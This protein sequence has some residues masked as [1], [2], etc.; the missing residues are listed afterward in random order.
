M[1]GVLLAQVDDTARA[2]ES[3][4]LPLHILGQ[5]Q[6][7]GRVGTL[8]GS[9]YD[10]AEDEVGD[11]VEEHLHAY[12]ARVHDAGVNGIH[13]DAQL[14][15]ALGQ[16]ECE[17]RD[18]QFAVAIGP[19]AQEETLATLLKHVGKVEPSQG[20]HA[21]SHVDYTSPLGH[22]RQEQA[23]EQVRAHIVHADGALQ[24]VHGEV[25]ARLQCAGIVHQSV[26]APKA[27]LDGK[28]KVAHGLQVGQVDA[29]NLNVGVAGFS[30]QFLALLLCLG[31][32]IA[33]H[34]GMVSGLGH[35]TG[36]LHA[37][38]SVGTGNDGYF[39]NY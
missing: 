3:A 36:F 22:Q 25:L 12:D 33:C 24:A 39:H 13:R 14:L 7:D 20:M 26:N 16:F 32:A 38:I 34:D 6:V 31:R 9:A 8:Q 15:Y 29:D 11:G 28:G 27:L 2:V 30:F 1:L 37:H 5:E 21:R 35:G 4:R 19:D 17:K 10:G 23:C 18:G